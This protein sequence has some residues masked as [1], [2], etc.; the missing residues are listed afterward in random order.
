MTLAATTVFVSVFVDV[1]VIVVV[2]SAE[3]SSA[4]KEREGIAVSSRVSWEGKR[5][6]LN[7]M[8]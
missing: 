3:G 2:G 6:I 8:L 7:L 1:E 5:R 4:A